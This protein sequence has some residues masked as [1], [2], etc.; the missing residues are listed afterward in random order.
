MTF[1]FILLTWKT[2]LKFILLTNS[3]R[4]LPLPPPFKKTQFNTPS[5]RYDATVQHHENISLLTEA[6]T[7]FAAAFHISISIASIKW[8]T[9]TTKSDARRRNNNITSYRLSR[10]LRSSR[11]LRT[12]RFPSTFDKLSACVV[13]VSIEIA[14]YNWK[15]YSRVGTGPPRDNKL[16]LSDCVAFWG[17]YTTVIR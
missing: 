9:I 17:N 15:Y 16:Q 2:I 8:E 1:T 13:R 4:I 12:Q 5:F 11:S 3:S 10:T 14:E 6:T 7:Y